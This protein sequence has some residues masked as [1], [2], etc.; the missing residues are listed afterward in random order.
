MN[1]R[2][3]DTIEIDGEKWH[4]VSVTQTVSRGFSSFQSTPS[5]ET[6]EMQLTLVRYYDPNTNYLPDNWV[7][8]I[9]D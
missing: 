9:D 2:P 6:V 1:M 3:P 8:L 4:V 5:R 7:A